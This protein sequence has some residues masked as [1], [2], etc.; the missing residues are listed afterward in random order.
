MEGSEGHRK[1][2]INVKIVVI[3]IADSLQT[4]DR[5]QADDVMKAFHDTPSFTFIHM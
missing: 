3:S 5:L 4:A 2:F 1:R